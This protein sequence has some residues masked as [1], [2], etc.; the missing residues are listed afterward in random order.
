MAVHPDSHYIIVCLGHIVKE[1]LET[2]EAGRGNI[3]GFEGG[4]AMRECRIY[5]ITALFICITAVKLCFPALPAQAAHEISRVICGQA[6]CGEAIQAM[7]RAIGRGELVQALN[8]LR[9]GTGVELIS[10]LGQEQGLQTED[11]SP[12]PSPIWP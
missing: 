5:I 7:G 9:S 8:D 12:A 6:D 3:F 4:A 2:Y 11:L 1:N 10:A